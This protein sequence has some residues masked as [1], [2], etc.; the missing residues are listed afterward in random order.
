MA[1]EYRPFRASYLI[2]GIDSE[3]IFDA[4]LDVRCFPEWA[5]GSR[6]PGLSTP[7]EPRP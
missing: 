4:L 2:S 3:K 6:T 1:D 7:R 5:A